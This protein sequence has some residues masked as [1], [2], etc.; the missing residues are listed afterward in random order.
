M[1]RRSPKILRSISKSRK[2]L[3][4]AGHSRDQAA[5]QPHS[6][7]GRTTR[8]DVNNES[9]TEMAAHSPRNTRNT[10][11]TAAQGA[12]FRLYRGPG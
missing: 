1:R 4:S 6:A 12:P 8:A 11:L 3:K 7:P 9:L 10:L 5:A 2:G